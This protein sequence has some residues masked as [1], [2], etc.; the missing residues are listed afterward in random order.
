MCYI[1]LIALQ[2][3]DMTVLCMQGAGDAAGLRV[4]ADDGLVPRLRL[5]GRGVGRDEVGEKEG[6][7]VDGDVVFIAEHLGVHLHIHAGEDVGVVT[8]GLHTPG[9]GRPD[10]EQVPGRPGLAW[11]YS[12]E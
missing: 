2:G 10:R 3:E 5:V 4:V 7:V 1:G 8:A 12:C 6:D 11:R 9:E